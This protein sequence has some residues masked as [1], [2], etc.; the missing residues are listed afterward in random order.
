VTYT[1]SL[2]KLEDAAQIAEIYR[3]YVEKTPISFEYDAPDADEIASRIN[4]VREAELPWLVAKDGDKIFG[5]A[6]ATKHKD[7]AG[8][9]WCVESSVY[10]ASDAHRAGIGRALYTRLFEILRDLGYHNVYAG[11]TLPN[12][13]SEKFHESFG[14]KEAGR[15]RD[16]G[17]KHGKWHDTVWWHLALNPLPDF[18]ELPRAL[19]E[20]IGS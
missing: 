13:Q 17:F 2:A 5:Y 15:Y 12:E 3:P 4:K 11:A 6:Y 9:Q 20:V 18:P 14:F 16:I 1:I 8:Y 10:V 7:R 19:H